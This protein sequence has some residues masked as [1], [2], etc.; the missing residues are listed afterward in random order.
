VGYNYRLSNILAAIGVAQMEVLEERVQA[1]RRNFEFYR[2]ALDGVPGIEWMP[3]SPWGRHTRWLTCLTVDP[4]EFGVNAETLRRALESRGI[5][6]RPVWKPMH[7]QPVFSACE[8]IG[9]DVA[10]DLFRRGLCLPSGS[11]LTDDELG[12]VAQ[13]IRDVAAAPRRNALRFTGISLP[14]APAA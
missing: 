3:E 6:A 4:V 2:S 5:E 8:R 1:R 14:V 9:G 7:M 13:V 11:N 10:G 12:R